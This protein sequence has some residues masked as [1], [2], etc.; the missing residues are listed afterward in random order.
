MKKSEQMKEM[1]LEQL[2]KTPIVEA[3]CQK[4]GISRMTFY[5]WKTDDEEFSKKVDEALGVGQFLI[6]DL[7]ESQ[8]IG[9][10]KERNLSA[11]T[12][13]LRHHHPDYAN[14]LEI[15]HDLKD[16]N[17]TPEQEAL[18][19]EALRLASGSQSEVININTEEQNDKS[20][21]DP[22]TGISGDNDQGQESPNSNN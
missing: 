17:L 22:A 9:A 8:L 2:R 6:N 1:I 16:E 21:I 11:I 20:K 19:R 14:K 13:W 5:R 15:K 10:V 18:V 4:T 12:Y 7:A 3:A